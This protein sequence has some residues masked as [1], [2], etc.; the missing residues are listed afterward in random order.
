MKRRFNENISGDIDNPTVGSAWYFWHIKM[1]TDRALIG[2]EMN[3]KNV[4]WWAKER[5]R[6]ESIRAKTLKVV[7]WELGI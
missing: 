3:S 1:A 2:N 4:E 6:I 7:A 5:A